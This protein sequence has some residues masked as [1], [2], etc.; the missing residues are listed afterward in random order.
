[1]NN[2]VEKVAVY[3][4]PIGQLAERSPGATTKSEES[5]FNKRAS[6][7]ASTAVFPR[8]TVFTVAAAYDAAAETYRS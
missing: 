7:T 8:P 6:A 5:K 2:Y 1:L 4:E 3:E